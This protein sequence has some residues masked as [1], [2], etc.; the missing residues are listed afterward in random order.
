MSDVPRWDEG[1][2]ESIEGTLEY[3]GL[4]AEAVAAARQSIAG[5]VSE[6]SR[7]PET[8]RRLAALQLVSY[9]LDRLG[10]HVGSSRRIL[11]DLRT[12]RRL[13]LGERDGADPGSPTRGVEVPSGRTGRTDRADVTGR[14]RSPAPALHP[15][16]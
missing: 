4:L 8:A 6:A 11:N 12:L 1:P 7:G 10:H 16:R 5:D 15:R 14:A 3:V 2:F 13:L 9:K